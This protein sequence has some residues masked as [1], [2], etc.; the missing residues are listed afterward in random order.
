MSYIWRSKRTVPVSIHFVV[1]CNLPSTTSLHTS[2]SHSLLS[3]LD[4]LN[5]SKTM[6][7]MNALFQKRKKKGKK[8]NSLNFNS[9][10]EIVEHIE[11][12][13]HVPPSYDH[14]GNMINEDEVQFPKAVGNYTAA[15]VS[16]TK[17]QKKKLDDSNG[18]Y[19]LVLEC[20]TSN[21]A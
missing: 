17:E 7:D 16:A 18:K 1:H 19:L 6:A 12:D 8:N 5:I 20:H 21:V 9:I 14:E 4:K 13:T 3:H 11:T 2:L 15:A 10:L